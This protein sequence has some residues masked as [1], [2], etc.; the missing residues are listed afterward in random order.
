MI[1]LTCSAWKPSRCS[2]N[3][4]YAAGGSCFQQ[5]LLGLGLAKPR[6][7]ARPVRINFTAPFPKTG[8][9]PRDGEPLRQW[10][11]LANELR[12]HPGQVPDDDKIAFRQ[13]QKARLPDLSR[14]TWLDLFELWRDRYTGG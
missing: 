4:T 13:V 5:V 9:A 3:R 11:T 12:T 10:D 2:N 1:L 6:S 8:L 7:C 14:E